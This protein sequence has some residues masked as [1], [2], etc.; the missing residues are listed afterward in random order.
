[1]KEKRK[2][3]KKVEGEDLIKDKKQQAIIRAFNRNYQIPETIRKII[4]KED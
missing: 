2:E 4:E 1:M 3:K